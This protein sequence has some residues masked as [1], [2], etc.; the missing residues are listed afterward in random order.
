MGSGATASARRRGAIGGVGLLREA[1]NSTNQGRRPAAA[2]LHGRRQR[3]GA[4]R[5]G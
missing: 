1:T 3:A 2:L 4:R 5:G